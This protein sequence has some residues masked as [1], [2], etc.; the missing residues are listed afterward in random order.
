MGELREACAVGRDGSTAANVLRAARRY[1]LAARGWRRA[2]RNLHRIPC[3]A[4]LFWEFNH[5]VVLEGVGRR[6]YYLN[7]PASGHRVVDFDTIDRCYTGVALEFARTPGFETSARPPGAI[8]RLWHY[9]R[10]FKP[11]LALAGVLGL[12]LAASMLA[13]PLLLTVLV[14]HV[15]LQG[16]TAWGVGLAALLMML[17]VLTYLLIWLQMR[18]L[19][20]LAIAISITQTDRFLTHLFKLPLQFF[21]QRLGGDLL[22][23]IQLIDDVARKAAVQLPTIAAEALMSLIFLA[24]MLAYDPVLALSLLALAIVLGLL[25]AAISRQR[26]DYSHLLQREQGLLVGVSMA[27]LRALQSMRAT[28]R[29][30]S[31]FAR[32]AGFQAKELQARQSFEELGHLAQALPSLFLM[33][34]SILVLGFGGWRALSGEM[35]LGV[36]MGFYLLAGNFLRPVGRLAVFTTELQPLHAD[37]RRLEDVLTAQPVE[38]GHA[39]ARGKG[40]IPT[41]NGRLKLTGKVELRD[42]T[43]G[44][45]AGKPPLIEDFS[46]SINP[47]ERIAVV[48][49][50]GCGK[51]SLSLLVAGV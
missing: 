34:G 46:L 37:L 28:A 14:D 44:Y 45:Q 21:S 33:L 9:L 11:S 42:V 6:R 39:A 26:V 50:T 20:R 32:W 5:F 19:R 4:I 10:D 24:V 25:V 27:G 18:V 22:K 38:R 23:R 31:F 8:R 15:L 41:L 40:G 1:G 7:D 3:P 35:S 51:T 17:G 16:R 2:V 47:G 13:V 12:L 36:L 29:E 43:F 49:P 30:N 48:G